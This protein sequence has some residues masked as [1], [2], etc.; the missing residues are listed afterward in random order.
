MRADGDVGVDGMRRWAL[1]S[2]RLAREEQRLGLNQ[3]SNLTAVLVCLRTSE[4]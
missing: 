4:L 3:L 1:G 2:G